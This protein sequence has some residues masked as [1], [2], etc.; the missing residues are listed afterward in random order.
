[1]LAELAGEF[2]VWAASKEAR[3]LKG[4]FAWVNWDVE[5]L[6]AAANDIESTR[7][8]TLGLDGLYPSKY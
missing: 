6:K 1:L 3:F 2:I 8:L 4:K 5:E 7:V